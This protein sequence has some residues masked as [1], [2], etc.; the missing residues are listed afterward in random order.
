MKRTRASRIQAEFARI[1]PD[2]FLIEMFPFGRKHFA[3]ELVPVLEQIRLKKMPTA[4][5]CSLRDIL[6]NNKRNQA[7][8]NERAITLMNR[9]FDLDRLLAVL[10][11]T[12]STPVVFEAPKPDFERTRTWPRTP[13]SSRRRSR[14]RRCSTP[15][16]TSARRQRRTKSRLT[17]R[18][19][20]GLPATL[21]VLRQR[22]VR[23][24]RRRRPREARGRAARADLDGLRAVYAAW[25]GASRSTTCSS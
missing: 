10:G 18:P 22:R 1:Q 16:P 7:Q 24:D 8:H 11:L 17:E 19:S 6:V 14:R 23:R 25:C 5:V 3:F 12:G 4:V 21:R 15:S 13:S 2:V 20:N 9:Y